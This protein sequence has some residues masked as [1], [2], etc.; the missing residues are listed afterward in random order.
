M[1]TSKKPGRQPQDRKPKQEK[2]EPVATKSVQATFERDGRELEGFAVTL[3]DVTVHVP[4]E[5]IN[6]FELMDDLNRL[7]TGDVRNVTAVASVLRRFI[8]AE[9]FKLAMDA[10][11]DPET[12]RVTIEAGTRFLFDMIRGINPNG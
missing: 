8:G 10:V 2:P 3:H 9:D 12:G 1:T 11:R 5:A 6:D 7:Q 4:T